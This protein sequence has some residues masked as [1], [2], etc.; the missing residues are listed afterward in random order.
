MTNTLE[1]IDPFEPFDHLEQRIKQVE[2]YTLSSLKIQADINKSYLEEFRLIH[3]DIKKLQ[4]D[5]ERLRRGINVLKRDLDEDEITTELDNI[6]NT[7][8]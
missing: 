1:H 3:H 6:I 4:M 7:K 2:E 5:I 8:R